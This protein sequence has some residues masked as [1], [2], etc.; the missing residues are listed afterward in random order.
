MLVHHGP[1]MMAVHD[2]VPA[3]TLRSLWHFDPSLKVGARITRACLERG[4]I[5]RALPAADTISFSPPFVISEDEIDT[6]AGVVGE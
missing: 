6:I 3:G 5:T 1:D 4:V 2:H